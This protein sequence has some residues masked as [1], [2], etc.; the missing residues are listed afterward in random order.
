M[1][2]RRPVGSVTGPGSRPT[3]YCS[4]CGLAL[5]WERGGWNAHSRR[6]IVLPCECWINARLKEERKCQTIAR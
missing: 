6:G 2:Q 3:I 4:A 1:S 5:E